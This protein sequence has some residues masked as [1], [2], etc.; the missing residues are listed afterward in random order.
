LRH[1]VQGSVE[2]HVL[3]PELLLLLLKQLVLLLQASAEDLLFGNVVVRGNPATTGNRMMAK[4]YHAPIGECVRVDGWFS[5]TGCLAAFANVVLGR[6][7]RVETLRDAFLQ[8]FMQGRAGL[9]LVSTKPVHA[10]V[11]LVASDQPLVGIEHTHA[12]PQA[13]QR[14]LEALALG[15]QLLVALLQGLA[16]AF[17]L[18][19]LATL[20]AE[21]ADRIDLN[22]VTCDVEPLAHD[23]DRD[24]GAGL[25]NQDG[26]PPRYCFA[27]VFSAWARKKVA[28]NTFALKA[29]RR[30]LQQ[31]TE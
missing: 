11:G 8:D 6:G 15:E 18:E 31:P 30:T 28:E 10:Q 12:L 25:R 27:Q 2:V 3:H 20:R 16:L 9:G 4:A 23:L 19:R 14:H 13:R 5:R 29:G 22:G 24:S 7:A 21:V 17:S 26:R 1:V